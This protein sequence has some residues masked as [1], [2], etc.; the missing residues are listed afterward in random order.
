MLT[1][2]ERHHLSSTDLIG[3]QRSHLRVESARPTSVL[4]KSWFLSLLSVFRRV[5]GKVLVAISGYLNWIHPN[6]FT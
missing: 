4:K 2:I 1:T 3:L 6:T 5:R